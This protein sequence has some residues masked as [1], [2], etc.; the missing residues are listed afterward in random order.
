MEQATRIKGKDSKRN[1]VNQFYRGKVEEKE[2]C[3]NL[4]LPSFPFLPRLQFA[5]KISRAEVT[6]LTPVT[7]V[8]VQAQ[9]R[10]SK[11]HGALAIMKS[12]NV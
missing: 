3:T 11:Y 10:G 7:A 4:V 6:E 8:P 2:L 12:P 5:E 1:I 9:A